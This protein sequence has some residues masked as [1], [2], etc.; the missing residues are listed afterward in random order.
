MARR[1][2]GRDVGLKSPIWPPSRN[3]TMTTRPILKTM[4]CDI[5]FRIA[6][7]RSGMQHKA[8]FTLL[9]LLVV[10]AIIA[11]LASMLLPSLGKAK[12]LAQS[13]ACQNHL[14]QL[15]LA[16][17][18]YTDEHDD[19]LPLNRMEPGGP[20]GEWWTPPAPVSWIA[21]NARW[22]T[23]ITNLERG[24]LFRYVSTAKVFRCPADRSK[25]ERQPQ[26]PR[27]RGYLLTAL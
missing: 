17:Q 19:H 12:A 8:A 25:I 21:G 14:R 2:G 3:E 10:I 22:D 15:Q 26:L 13:T 24:T 1:R 7:R 5:G 27:T 9:E 11:I 20:G 6:T 16:W 18:V 23:T 4:N